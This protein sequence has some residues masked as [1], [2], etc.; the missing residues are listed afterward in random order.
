MILHKI[1]ALFEIVLCN[2]KFFFSLLYDNFHFSLLL[3]SLIM[4]YVEGCRSITF[5]W[6]FAKNNICSSFRRR[7][8]SDE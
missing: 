5:E 3:T 4:R 8:Y 6:H 1:V 7:M 2:V